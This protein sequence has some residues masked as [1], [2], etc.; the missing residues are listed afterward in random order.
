[1]ATVCARKRK[2]ARPKAE[3]RGLLD[4]SQDALD[5]LRHA[6]HCLNHDQK[7]VWCIPRPRILKWLWGLGIPFFHSNCKCNEIIAISNRALSPLESITEEGEKHLVRIRSAALRLGRSLSVVKLSRRS[8]VLSVKVPGKRK[9]YERAK[10]YLDKFGLDLGNTRL[11]TFVK[12]E[13]VHGESKDP[14]PIQAASPEYNIELG[15]YNKPIEELLGKLRWNIA[16][17]G[18][19]TGRLIAKGLNNVQR[20][21]L[22]SKKFHAFNNPVVIGIDASRF[23]MHVSRDW[24]K[25][26]F[27][28]YKGAYQHDP[29]LS[30]LLRWQLGPRGRT[31]KGVRYTLN[32]GRCSGV[33]NTGSGNSFV[34]CFLTL[35]YLC[36]RGIK[37]DFLC[38]GDDALI[39]LEEEDLH[40]L[41]E[42]PEYCASLGF[43]M[44]IEA[45]ARSLEDI[46]FCQSRP[47]EVTPGK[48]VMVRNPKRAL[49]RGAMS[50]TSMATV[51]EAKQTLW[52]IGSCE[53]ALHSGVPVMQEY[54][55]WCL[56]N[57]VKPSQRKLEMIKTKLSHNYWT[58]PKSQEPKPISIG[59]RITFANAFGIPLAEQLM[60]EQAFRSSDFTMSGVVDELPT[61]DTGAGE[62]F[63]VDDK[64]YVL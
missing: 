8:F 35:N 22:I 13:Q 58:L 36:S 50:Q 34:C 33:P 48:W 6:P 40:H 14:R 56:R 54:A 18:A 44:V 45:P 46:E 38:D 31:S 16:F 26:E 9:I 62:V 2:I 60:L 21:A 25:V 12:G 32:G 53:L 29:Y 19:P 52:A 47:I 17:P 24:L 28:I 63:S 10:V 43:R 15:C 64:I 39:F 3:M 41:G 57:G 61:E 49:Y 42:F 59:A 51:I 4:V 7:Y 5:S 1:M 20:G 37:F 55:L 27:E 11:S 23:D 30:S